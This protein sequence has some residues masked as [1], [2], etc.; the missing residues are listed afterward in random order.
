MPKLW[1][2]EVLI[3]EVVGSY[4]GISQDEALFTFF[5]EHSAHFF[6][7]LSHVHR[8]TFVRQAAILWAIK[9][10][11][12]M[13][14][15]DE[16]IRHDEWVGVIDSMPLPACRTNCLNAHAAP[17]DL[18]RPG[19]PRVG[20]AAAPVESAAQPESAHAASHP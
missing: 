16:L 8:S 12:W 14:L 19:R 4:L 10:H 7:S 20:L 1:D 6:P 2:S 5:R 15:R 13:R 3:M 9:E 17:C 11:L 18:A